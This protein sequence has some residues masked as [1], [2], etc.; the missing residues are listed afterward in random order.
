MP[1]SPLNIV[2]VVKGNKSLWGTSKSLKP[3]EEK[4][5]PI[6]KIIK[7][8]QMLL[9]HTYLLDCKLVENSSVLDTSLIPPLVL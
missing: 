8:K 1:H 9:F 4:S 2:K 6:H 7:E 3:G 5:S